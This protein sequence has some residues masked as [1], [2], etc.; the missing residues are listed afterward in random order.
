MKKTNEQLI[1]EY[2]AKGGKI[3]KLPPQESP[4]TQAVYK[5]SSSGPAKI[6]SLSEGEL[7]YGE[8]SRRKKVKELDLSKVDLD[9]IPEELKKKLGI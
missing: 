2:L 8:T 3:T 9:E 6:M 1:E 5:P 7:F 4:E